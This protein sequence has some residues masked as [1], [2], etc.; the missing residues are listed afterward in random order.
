MPSAANKK[1]KVMEKCRVTFDYQA[2]TADELTLVKGD[3]I[4]ILNKNCE[5][6]GWWEGERID[7]NGKYVFMFKIIRFKVNT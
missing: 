2:Q 4:T 1:A 6:P 5:D 7:H 3:I